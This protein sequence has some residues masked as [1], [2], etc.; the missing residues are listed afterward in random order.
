MEEV[1]FELRL[2]HR[3]ESHTWGFGVN[4]TR[5]KSKARSRGGSACLL[6]KQG[7]VRVETAKVK[8][9]TILCQMVESLGCHCGECG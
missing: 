5:T 7:V 6:T 4:G 2:Q 9:K 3:S 1:E 8:S